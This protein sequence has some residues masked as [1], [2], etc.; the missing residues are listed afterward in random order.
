MIMISVNIAERLFSL[1]HALN[2]EI[3]SILTI[4]L[5]KEDADHFRQNWLEIY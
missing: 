4:D 1:L 3:N 2:V 5:E